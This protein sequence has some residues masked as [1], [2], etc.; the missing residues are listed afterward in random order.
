MSGPQHCGG[1]DFHCHLD[2]YPD[3]EAAIA[4]A[5]AASVY[6]LTVTTTPKAWPRNRKLTRST[7]YVRAALGLHPQLVAERADELSLWEHYLSET[8][9]V[10]EVGLDA[11]P[12]FYKSLDLQKRVFRAVL[13]RCAEARGK[14]LT[15]HSVR[16]VPAVLAMVE[17]YL[18]QDLGAVVLH[19]F[20]GSRAEARRAGAL[21]C[22]FSVNAEMMRTERGRN[23]IADLPADRILTETD[24][25][26]TKIGERP[27]EPRD[28]QATARAIARVRNTSPEALTNAIAANL[29]DLLRRDGSRGTSE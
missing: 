3:H 6:T 18:P 9:Y 29:R 21:G 27:A 8:R 25:P 23:L 10:G 26:F 12:R 2:L 5:E 4:R 20:T 11:G 7:R 19:W 17:Q 28:S 24:G 1:V 16:S 13:E 22:Y 15:V 14:I